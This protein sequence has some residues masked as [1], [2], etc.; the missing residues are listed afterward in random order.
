MLNREEAKRI[1][2]TLDELEVELAASG[3]K[4]DCHQ[5][6]DQLRDHI[7]PLVSEASLLTCYP[8]EV[9]RPELSLG[10]HHLQVRPLPDAPPANPQDAYVTAI[11]QHD[12]GKQTARLREN[13]CVR[14]VQLTPKLLPGGVKWTARDFLSRYAPKLVRARVGRNDSSLLP[15]SAWPSSRGERTGPLPRPYLR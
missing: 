5:V 4:A 11:V 1:L 3:A 10:F 8:T 7:I 2:D 9:A 12:E 15:P 6:L 13:G 14:Y